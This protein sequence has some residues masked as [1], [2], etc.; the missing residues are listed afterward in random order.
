MLKLENVTVCYGATVAVDNVSMDVN[1]GEFVTLIGANGAGK[2]TTL[3]AIS[4]LEPVRSGRIL[5]EGDPIQN[6]APQDIIRLGIAHCPEG[7]R[8]FP[9]LTVR[10]NLEMGA[11]RRYDR[12]GIKADI[13]RML[14]MFPRLAERI[15]QSAGTLSG[16]EQ[17]MLAIARALMSRPRL[18]MFDEPSLGLA[19]N[20]V[21][22]V[23][24]LVSE[25]CE[26]GTTVLMVEQNAYAALELCDRSYLLSTGEVM[27]SGTAEEMLANPDIRRIYLG[28]EAASA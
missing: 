25:I 4:G 22:Q 20:F 21:E 17:Q 23:F 26:G 27:L 13:D 11:F 12:Q 24:K 9:Q 1:E 15:R 16:G 7:R 28:G 18:V 5:F 6:A 10:E 19:P 8:V 14:G 2:S 3:R